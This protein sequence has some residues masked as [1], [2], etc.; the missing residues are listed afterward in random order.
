M[1]RLSNIATGLFA[2]LTG[3]VLIVWVIPAQTVPAIFASVPSG[4]YPNFTSVML[5]A[6]GLA[7]AVSGFV[8]S[9]PQVTAT[10]A[11]LIAVRFTV[12]LVLLAG[13]MLATPIVGF[14]PAGVAICL[15]TLVLMRENRWL[16]TAAI[17]IA[18]PVVV[19]AG[20]ELLLGRPLP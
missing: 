4:F 20:F 1:G 6:S 17:C 12:A 2:A 5:I 10:P 8:S 16:L 15:I 19:W 9:P 14:V 13:A 18:A 11:G 7:L 3:L